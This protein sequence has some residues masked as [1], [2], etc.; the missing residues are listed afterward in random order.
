MAKGAVPEES[1]QK[2]Q[3]PLFL[4]ALG[5]SP[6]FIENYFVSNLVQRTLSHLVGQGDVR[7]VPIRATGDGRLM[8]AIAAAGY[9]HNY[10][11]AK[12]ACTDSY[13]IKIFPQVMARIDITTW[14]FGIIIQRRPYAEAGWEG[15]IEIPPNAFYSF[16][17]SSQ[18]I[19]VKNA[20]PGSNASCQLVGW[21]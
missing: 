20:T 16:D 9:E 10:T 2:I 7:A 19:Q 6:E 18:A 21:Y 12:F 17:C 4:E 15:E 13:A 3:E 8:V 1:W 14:N 5:F 11:V